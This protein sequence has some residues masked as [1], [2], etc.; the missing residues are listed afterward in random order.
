[1]K[2]A[3][4][5][6]ILLLLQSAQRRTAQELAHATEVSTRTIY[7]DIE[8]L[9]AAGVPIHAE[10][11]HEGG[12]VLAEGYRRALVHFGEDEIRAL[13]VSGTAVLADL[14]LDANLHHA[15]EKLRGGLSHGQQFIARRSAERIH[16][17]QRRWNHDDPPV[18]KL[19]LLRRA[20]WEDHRVDVAYEDRKGTATTRTAEPLGLVSKAGVWYVVAG[21]A[22]GLRSFRVDR[23]R[24][25]H[26]RNDH[27]V[28]PANFELDK[29]WR[30]SSTDIARHHE[31]S[32]RIET[33]VSR[34]ALSTVCSYWPYVVLAEGDPALVA[35]RFPNEDVALATVLSW[36]H[37]VEVTDPPALRAA[38][39]RRACELIALYGPERVI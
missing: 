8:A 24:E 26:E 15:L 16:I 28:R 39:A 5:V 10:R 30:E 19:T 32:F 9:C 1:M 29:Y 33:R 7:R 2:A 6:S 36:G 34:D 23:I 18:E 37:T 38:L 20:I 3:R 17:D 22:S 13:F 21:T 12:I 25:L 11:G 14:G 27:F 35:I 4:L 31:A